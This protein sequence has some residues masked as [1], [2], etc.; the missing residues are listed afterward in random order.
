MAAGELLVGQHLE[1]KTFWHVTH[2]ETQRRI[3]RPSTKGTKLGDKYTLGKNCL[4]SGAFGK[5]FEARNEE[6]GTRVAVKQARRDAP[7]P[8]PHILLSM[9][10][11]LGSLKSAGQSHS[12]GRS[13]VD[14]DGDSTLEDAGTQEYCEVYRLHPDCL[15]LQHYP[16]AC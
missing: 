15:T 16:R 8:E 11:L 3:M 14:R 10:C 9:F 12:D 6:T 13:E 5:V 2:A 1:E 7:A 4:G